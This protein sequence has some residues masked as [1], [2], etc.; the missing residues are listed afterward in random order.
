M[1]LSHIYYAVKNASSLATFY[2]N[3]EK[4]SAFVAIFFK[5]EGQKSSSETQI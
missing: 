2:G 4:K 3:G 1:Q 5:I